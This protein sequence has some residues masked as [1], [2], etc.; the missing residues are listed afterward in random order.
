MNMK[1]IAKPHLRSALYFAIFRA[2]KEAGVE[3]PFPQ[4]DLHLRSISPET[5][6]VLAGAS[7]GFAAEDAED[8]SADAFPRPVKRPA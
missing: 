1:T 5:V 8:R 6:R 2:F 4:R 3:I 7:N